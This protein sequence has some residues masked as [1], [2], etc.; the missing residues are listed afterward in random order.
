MEQGGQ[1]RQGASRPPA[2]FKLGGSPGFRTSVRVEQPAQVLHVYAYVGGQA[3]VNTPRLHEE[4]VSFVAMGGDDLSPGSDRR[5]CFRLLSSERRGWWSRNLDTMRSASIAVVNNAVC[6]QRTRILL[7]TGST[8][9][10]LSL[11]LARRLKL[12]LDHDNRLWV[13]GIDGVTTH[14]TARALVKIML[15]S[16][17]VYFIDIWVGNIG[18]DVE[19]LLGMD[20]MVAAGVRL[21]ALEG[22]AHLPDEGR[23]PLVAPGARPHEG[24]NI[25]VA[26]IK[27]VWIRLG[28][29]W[30]RGDVPILY[31]PRTRRDLELW[32]CSD[33]RW[34]TTALYDRDGLLRRIRVTNVSP[35]ELNLEAHT[36]VAVLVEQAYRP[37]EDGC[38]RA[39]V[40]GTRTGEAPSSSGPPRGVNG[41]ASKPQPSGTTLGYYR[42]SS[43]RRIRH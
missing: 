10:I 38:V 17:A 42:Q 37:G 35:K 30:G 4:A 34:L 25:P 13:S 3:R 23:I 29:T 1:C 26:N 5:A 28:D 14:I 7:D 11:S 32:V 19:C 20:F 8:T 27:D 22:N 18:D 31:G 2:S 39:R 6:N 41:I 9:S 36:T 43:A 12:I 15:G 33:V 40:R 24:T 21:S 16:A